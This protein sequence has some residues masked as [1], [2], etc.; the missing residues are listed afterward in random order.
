MSSVRSLLPTTGLSR[1]GAETRRGEKRFIRGFRCRPEP[2]EAVLRPAQR[3][4]HRLRAP[5]ERAVPARDAGRRAVASRHYGEYRRFPGR[6]LSRHAR[7]EPALASTC[8]AS[9]ANLRPW[10]AGRP[11]RRRVRPRFPASAPATSRAGSSRARA[12]G[13]RGGR[14][15]CRSGGHHRGGEP[16]SKKCGWPPAA[17]PSLCRFRRVRAGSWLVGRRAM[18]SAGTNR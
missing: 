11:V 3:F 13:V 16:S 10:Q 12:S 7:A 2:R 15:V 17:L 4:A 5:R 6:H 18:P 8:R 14:V 1:R 9:V